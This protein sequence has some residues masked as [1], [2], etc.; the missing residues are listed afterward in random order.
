MYSHNLYFQLLSNSANISQAYSVVTDFE[1]GSLAIDLLPILEHLPRC[2]QW[3]H[4]QLAPLV[5]RE[6]ALHL[7]FLTTL[8][9]AVDAGNAP[10]CFGKMLIE[11]LNLIYYCL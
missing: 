3:W 9:K 6:S 7:A 1:P 8:R 11:V 5:G 2:L 10:D 4:H